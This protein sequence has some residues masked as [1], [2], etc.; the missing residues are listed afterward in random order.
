[1]QEIRCLQPKSSCSF[2]LPSWRTLG[3]SI[4]QLITVKAYSVRL[5]W[6]VS[7][8]LVVATA[9]ALGAVLGHGFTW[10]DH[11]HII[12]NLLLQPVTWA[13]VSAFWQAPYERLYI[14]LTYTVWA[15]VVWLTQMCLPGPLTA[16]LFHRLNLLLHLGNVLV[17]YRLGLL[18]VQPG[19]VE[20]EARWV[21]AA[22]AGAFLFGVHPLQVE[23]VAWVSGLK[24]VL[25]GWWA[26][27]A[28]W[29][30]LVYLQAPQ[31]WRQW[32]HYG[33][34]TVAFGL[35]LL[36]KPTAVV[37]P[38][39]AG[40]LAVGSMGQPWRQGLK[41]LWGWF[42]I[43]AV[44]SVWTKEQQPDRILEYI[45]PWWGRPVVAIDAIAFYLGKVVWPVALGPDYGRTPQMVLGHGWSWITGLV[46]AGLG[47]VLWWK[48]QQWSAAGVVAGVFVVAILPVSGLVPFVFQAHSTV[49]DRYVYL[50]MLGPALGLAWVLRRLGSRRTIWAFSLVG[51]ML[52]GW[53]STCQEQVWRDGITLFT[54]ASQLNPRSALAYN[55]LGWVLARQGQLDTAMAYYTEALRLKPAMYEAHANLGDALATQGKLEEAIAHYTVVLQLK[56]AWAEVHNNLG[57]ALLRQGQIDQAIEHY[58]QALRLKPG[59]ALATNNL[60]EAMVRQGKLNQAIAWFSQAVQEKP[61]LPEAPYNLGGVLSLQSRFTEAIAAYRE[62]LRRRPHWPQAA[63]HLAWVLATQPTPS[64]QDITDAVT[65]ATEACQASGFRHALPLRTLAVAYHVA[66]QEQTAVHLA[67]QALTLAQAM[68]DLRLIAQLTEELHSYR[69]IAPPHNPS[70]EEVSPAY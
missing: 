11:L 13:H 47:C 57:A 1:M 22:A 42:L 48:R 38:G 61:A 35:A 69:L 64:A 18:V 25:C 36:S 24:D 2:P 7:V 44:W 5:T 49:A 26:L 4:R 54:H 32:S 65:L 17:V 20:H 3:V 33:L 40:L 19:E 34:A 10:D 23:A 50:A 39:I 43:T 41:A 6:L 27:V 66:G 67:S 12:D 58:T 31:G 37:V 15:A 45:P 28:V 56:P 16:S 51:L 46:M 52:L 14:P 30:Y 59:W 9:V 53:R 70:E 8:P 63:T 29:Q 60:G 21:F 55:N 68:H 62:A